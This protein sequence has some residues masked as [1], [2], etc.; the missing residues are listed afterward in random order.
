MMTDQCGDAQHV[1]RGPANWRPK[2]G[3]H[4]IAAFLMAPTS[5]AGLTSPNFVQN[6]RGFQNLA[7]PLRKM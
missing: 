3:D 7:L 6:R 2:L 1:L 5:V 4:S